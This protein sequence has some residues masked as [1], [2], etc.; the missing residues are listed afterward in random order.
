MTLQ[1]RVGASEQRSAFTDQVSGKRKRGRP[2]K[3]KKP[4]YL[5]MQAMIAKRNAVRQLTRCA[6]PRLPLPSH[7]ITSHQAAHTPQITEKRAEDADQS[8]STSDQTDMLTSPDR[9]VYK[10]VTHSQQHTNNIGQT[11]IVP[12]PGSS[13]F[14]SDETQLIPGLQPPK[15]RKKQRSLKP[16]SQ[17]IGGT[18]H[19][20]GGFQGAPFAHAYMK[21]K[22]GRPPKA[23]VRL[24]PVLLVPNPNLQLMSGQGSGAAA[25][26]SHVVF[27]QGQTVAPIVVQPAQAVTST[28]AVSSLA[29]RSLQVAS[30]HPQ[31]QHLCMVNTSPSATHPFSPPLNSFPLSSQQPMTSAALTASSISSPFKHPDLIKSALF[32]NRSI[33]SNAQ[34]ASSATSSGRSPQQQQHQQQQQHSRLAQHHPQISMSQAEVLAAQAR[35]LNGFERQFAKFVHRPPLLAPRQIIVPPADVTSRSVA[36]VDT[37]SAPQIVQISQ[38]RPPTSLSSCQTTFANPIVSTHSQF[39]ALSLPRASVMTPQ[40]SGAFATQ[41]LVPQPDV[42]K[43]LQS[44]SALQS[45]IT[46]SNMSA[47]AV[48]NTMLS[49]SIVA[50][51]FAQQENIANGCHY[52][53][54]SA[55][56]KS[57]VTS[58]SLV[59]SASLARSVVSSLVGGKQSPEATLASIDAIQRLVNTNPTLLQ[60]TP[61]PRPS[62]TP[63]H[64]PNPP[65]TRPRLQWPSNVRPPK[66][67]FNRLSTAKQSPNK[68]KRTSSSEVHLAHKPDTTPVRPRS[69]DAS[70]SSTSSSSPASSN[71]PFHLNTPTNY[72]MTS[73]DMA[74][75]NHVKQ[76]SAVKPCYRQPPPTHVMT[77]PTAMTSDEQ[78][79]D[80]S[81]KKSKT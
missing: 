67:L 79:L 62:Y 34:S 6:T 39:A 54:S 25:L 5:A 31:A 59:T 1:R 66:P 72:S 60:M 76:V 24:P 30:H 68:L 35:N 57:L 7:A 15:R 27:D 49:Q 4:S 20:V 71:P 38:M 44:T 8:S 81:V 22:R 12:A 50:R 41:T 2:P 73:P 70:S 43:S 28:P 53:T 36:V 75:A 52:V 45:G 47:N 69:S 33:S 29:P 37:T 42:V 26:S 13:G 74:L 48:A 9:Y 46:F 10:T 16:L 77:S 23:S 51:S 78:P 18:Y 17:N 55:L 32:V 58:Q 21:R 65:T 63:F 64:R 56:N 40:L 11:F 19:V 14:T 61:R 80:F 3:S